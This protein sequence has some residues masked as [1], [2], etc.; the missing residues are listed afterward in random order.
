[1]KILSLRLRNLN[2]LKGEWKID[3]ANAPF[4]DNGLF[5]ITGSTGA[6]KTTLLDAICL[7]LYHRTPR[8]ETVSAGG[9]ELMTRHT[10][11]CLAEVEFEV[12]G[13]G[14]RAFWSQRRARDKADGNLQAPKVEL[15]SLDGT[16]ITE[17]IQ[18]KLRATES[19][20]GLDFGRFTKSMMLAQGGFAAFLEAKANER[21]ELLEELTGTDIYGQ[22][23]QRVFERT[24]DEKLELDTL[25]VRAEGVVLLDDAQRAALADEADALGKTETQS[26]ARLQTLHALIQWWGDLTKAELEHK[27]AVEARHSASAAH[28]LAR[29]DLDRLAASEPAEKLRAVHTSWRTSTQAHAAATESLAQAR[30]AHR[31]ASVEVAG[32]LWR[33]VELRR[34]IE[35][36]IGQ[37]V[38]KA[39]EDLNALDTLLAQYPAREKLGEALVQWRAQ[40]DWRRQRLGEI[41]QTQARANTLGTQIA[42][43]DDKARRSHTALVNAQ[44]ALEVTQRT[45]AEHVGRLA[46]VLKGRDEA[47]VRRSWQAL[48]SQQGVLQQLVQ[49]AKAREDGARSLVQAA[50]QLAARERAR[51]DTTTAREQIEQQYRVVRDQVRDKEKL[52]E[53]ERRIHELSAYRAALRPG[54]PCELCGSTEHPAISTYESLDLSRTQRELEQTRTRLSELE[55]QGRTLATAIAALAGEIEQIGRHR[56]ALEKADAELAARWVEQCEAAALDIADRERL[57]TS[58]DA[59]A[60]AMRDVQ[61]SLQQIEPLREARDRAAQL[62]VA[63]DKALGEAR[64][65]VQLVEQ[66]RVNATAQREQTASQLA[67]WRVELDERTGALNT[68]VQAAG[69]TGHESWDAPNAWLAERDAEWQA[70]QQSRERRQR[71]EREIASLAQRLDGARQELDKWQSRW[72]ALIA[73]SARERDAR[74]QRAAERAQRVRTAQDA[75]AADDR[76]QGSLFSDDG[77]SQSD[78]DAASTRDRG[79]PDN[80]DASTDLDDG[81]P[82]PTDTF[83]VSTAGFEPIAMAQ[84]PAREFT[85]AEASLERAQREEGEWAGRVQSLVARV[86][87]LARDLSEASTHWQSALKSSP[88]VDEVSFTQALIDPEARDRLQQLRKRL[89]DALLSARTLEATAL[90]RVSALRAEARTETSATD[91]ATERDALQ[92]SLRQLTERQGEIKAQLHNDDRQRTAKQSLFEQI[93]AK[94]ATLDVWQRLNGL[95]G[96]ADGAKYRKFA[97]GLTLDHLIHL[98]NRQLVRLHG[99]Y[100]LN[101]KT[102]AEL[103]LEVVDTW[104]GDLARDTRTLSGGESFLVSLALALALSDLVSHKTSIDSLFLDEGFGT[105]DGETLDIALDALDALN[106]SG[107]TIGVISHVEALKER[108]PVQIKVRKRAGVGYSDIEVTG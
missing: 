62:R 63:A 41:D 45:E 95:I 92:A 26:A 56:A 93:G 81:D 52:I 8:M 71:L 65:A 68:A 17:K 60:Q 101:R 12:K 82:A 27:Q 61:A 30:L 9:N 106:A 79:A 39:R 44:A 46:E 23:S 16:I 69:Y 53:Q 33:A 80:A 107:K 70:W 4:K 57:Q 50:E 5:A 31:Q 14:Y 37:S 74:A 35:A 40:L 18:D 29:P 13:K 99:R 2:S 38:H 84:D 15:A 10:F 22:I 25:Q 19:I 67:L 42:T 6:G 54:E 20:T 3:F 108:I 11:D 28:T 64:H 58:I 76:G 7:A 32:S 73:A 90:Q 89:D 34:Q 51:A 88:F 98:A 59:N 96:S 97:Q 48:Q 91:L 66:E 77:P 75:L 83:D 24:R 55:T 94:R 86:D 102:S 100:A 105:L 87:A 103:E 36:Q 85:D 1:M 78:E 21:A 43:L 49:I 104:Q 72:D 47:D